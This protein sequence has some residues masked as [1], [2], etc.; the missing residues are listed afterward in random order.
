MV[1]KL[2]YGD[3]QKPLT[4]MPMVFGG[5]IT[6]GSLWKAAATLILEQGAVKLR[7]VEWFHEHIPF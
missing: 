7:D 6:L 3:D 2:R 1:Y 4:T 5:K